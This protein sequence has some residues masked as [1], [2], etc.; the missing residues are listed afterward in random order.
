[1]NNVIEELF[2]GKR[3]E[4]STWFKITPIETRE[5]IN[6]KINDF[7]KSL[8][9][10]EGYSKEET[11]VKYQN[12]MMNCFGINR[13]YTYL[14]DSYLTRFIHIG[15]DPS[16]ADALIAVITKDNVNTSDI[17]TLYPQFKDTYKVF[18][19]SYMYV[20]DHINKKQYIDGMV[21]LCGK[22]ILNSPLVGSTYIPN[23]RYVRDYVYNIFYAKFA[24]VSNYNLWVGY[25]KANPVKP[26]QRPKMHDTFR[27][28]LDIEEKI[29][30]LIDVINSG[31]NYKVAFS[32]KF[33]NKHNIMVLMEKLTAE[34][35]KT[36]INTSLKQKIGNSVEKFDGNETKDLDDF[37]LILRSLNKS[38]ANRIAR[39]Y[40]KSCEG[41]NTYKEL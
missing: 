3:K 21:E 9:D 22:P 20:K 31:I 28:T 8:M 13:Y 34:C 19:L 4:R 29:P 39:K 32:K 35:N 40:K 10:V 25:T 23:H 27:V 6:M 33:V 41:Y 1:M 14:V 36:K 17:M 24:G 16:K 26:H 15:K 11:I 37:C 7:V 2:Y 12:R 5:E 30:Y 18:L 38:H